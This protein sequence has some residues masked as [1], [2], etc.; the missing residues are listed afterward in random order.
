MSIY[1]KFW[2]GISVHG[3]AEQEVVSHPFPPLLPLV[4]AAS[5]SIRVSVLRNK[6]CT[7][8][9]AALFQLVFLV[10][11]LNCWDSNA[12]LTC[13]RIVL[14]ACCPRVRNLKRSCEINWTS[15][16]PWPPTQPMADNHL[17]SPW[18]ESDFFH[19]NQSVSA[20]RDPRSSRSPCER[21]RLKKEWGGLEKQWEGS[22]KR[23]KK[24]GKKAFCRKRVN[25]DGK[26]KFNDAPEPARGPPSICCTPSTWTDLLFWPCSFQKCH[27]R[28]STSSGMAHYPAPA[29][30]GAP[31]LY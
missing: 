13:R 22:G 16:S 31:Q 25:F 5:P 18:Q 27:S 20:A 2:T 11:V 10:S 3:D 28:T 24:W 29:P 21:R 7:V 14:P 17:G 12:L 26:R 1:S 8:D 9:H 19:L 30:R 4:C 23:E 15:A 6:N